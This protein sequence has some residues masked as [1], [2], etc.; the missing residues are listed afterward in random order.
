MGGLV[1]HWPS[2][3]SVRASGGAGSARRGFPVSKLCPR[4]VA[5]LVR[6]TDTG[7]CA[8]PRGKS[9]AMRRAKGL[10]GF[11]V[12]LRTIARDQCL[13]GTIHK[14][15]VGFHQVIS[16]CE[17]IALVR[18][19]DADAG[20]KTCANDG[21]GSA[22]TQDS[23]AVVEKCIGAGCEAITTEVVAHHTGPVVACRLGLRCCPHLRW[24]R[25]VPS[26]RGR[27]VPRHRRLERRPASEFW[28]LR[29]VST[30]A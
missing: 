20:V 18:M 26:F 10:L 3:A 27:Q 5:S 11:R 8:S 12:N 29:F 2:P 15:T 30:L 21:A 19:V 24:L 1:G 14:R 13:H 6:A 17:C 28:Q 7:D 16:Q 23:I 22:C 25:C 4:D 9:R